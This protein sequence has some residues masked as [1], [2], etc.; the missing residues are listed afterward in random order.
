MSSQCN[1][2]VYE[3]A[4]DAVPSRDKLAV[5]DVYVAR[6]AALFGALR[7]RE[8]Y[9]HTISGGGLP[10]EDARMMSVRFANLETGL[11]EVECARA[12]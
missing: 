12:L 7:M 4:M 9:Q 6:A 2:R 5:Y 11:E 3:D 10:D 1:V 8:V